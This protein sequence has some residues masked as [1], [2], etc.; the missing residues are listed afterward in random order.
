MHSLI[1]GT[2][3][4]GKSTLARE[5]LYHWRKQKLEAI[6]FDPLSYTWYDAPVYPAIETFLEKAKTVTNHLLIIDESGT[7]LDRY[8][9]DHLW[10]ATRSRHYGHSCVFISQRANML[11]PN[12]RHNCELLYLFGSSPKDIQLLADDFVHPEITDM[13][14]LEKYQFFRIRRFEAVSRR[15]LN[16]KTHSTIVVQEKRKHEPV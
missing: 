12:I 10:L 2:T 1:V 6:V 14:P 15:M 13:P 16:P 5:I 7:S 3:E 11:S 4:S 8:D 9:A